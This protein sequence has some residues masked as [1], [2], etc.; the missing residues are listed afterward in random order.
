MSL[1]PDKENQ[2]VLALIAGTLHPFGVDV[3]E[4]EIDA[5]LSR[6]KPLSEEGRVALAN[7][8]DDPFARFPQP[9]LRVSASIDL[10]H[11]AAMHR[12]AE[13]AELDEETQAKLEEKRE[14][15][16]ERLR[17]RKSQPPQ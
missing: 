7:L 15:V 10:G 2:A 12:E 13:S 6:A 9:K 8:G 4:Q 11:L 3:T 16:L 17:N 5:V 1:N 14:E